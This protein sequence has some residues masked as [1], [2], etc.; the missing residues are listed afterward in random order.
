[1]PTWHLSGAYIH[2]RMHTCVHAH[3]RARIRACVHTCMHAHTRG[4]SQYLLT[5]LLT[6]YLLT[7][8]LVGV[9]LPLSRASCTLRHLPRKWCG[10]PG[11]HTDHRSAGCARGCAARRHPAVR[12]CLTSADRRHHRHRLPLPSRPGDHDGTASVQFFSSRHVPCVGPYCTRIA[13]FLQICS[14][15]SACAHSR[16][17]RNMVS[18]VL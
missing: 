13:G 16:I 9:E 8:Q 5:G 11:G 2:T 1:M 3:L 15:K 10:P 4:P 17:P 7:F 14:S 18:H 6:Y 12:R